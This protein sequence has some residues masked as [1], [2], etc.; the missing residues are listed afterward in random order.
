MVNRE[1]TAPFG[2]ETTLGV[3]FKKAMSVLESGFLKRG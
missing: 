3:T 1:L 2:T